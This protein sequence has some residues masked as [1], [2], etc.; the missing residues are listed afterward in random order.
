MNVQDALEIGTKQS[1]EMFDSL[2]ADF[3]KPIKKKVKTM[4]ILKKSVTVH[5]HTVYDLDT[6]FGRLLAVGQHRGI[7]IGDM[8]KFELSPIPPAIIDEYG[9]L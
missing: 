5:G 4:E 8:L 2:S 9:C 6:L 7:D 1:Q 3:H